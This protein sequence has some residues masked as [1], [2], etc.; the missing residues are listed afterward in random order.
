MATIP[1]V[2][3]A[4]ITAESASAI[5]SFTLHVMHQAAV[6]ST[7]IGLSCDRSVSKLASSNG[8]H[9][10]PV[11]GGPGDAGGRPPSSTKERRENAPT[12]ASVDS[13]MPQERHRP[14]LRCTAL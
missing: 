6:T 13:P 9:A 8:R 14:A 12:V 2:A 3:T 11:L 1:P 4:L 7:K 5:R 10:M